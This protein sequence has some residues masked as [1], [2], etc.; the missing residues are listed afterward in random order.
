MVIDF[1]SFGAH[2]RRLKVVS[3]RES[4]ARFIPARPHIWRDAADGP[5]SAPGDYYPR[6]TGFICMGGGYAGIGCTPRLAW[7]DWISDLGT[8]AYRAPQQ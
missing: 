7:E 6:G 4:G 2:I 5:V 3:E 8:C 1:D